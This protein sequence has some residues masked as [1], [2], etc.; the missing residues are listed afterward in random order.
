M[1]TSWE[2]VKA[3][4]EDYKLQHWIFYKTNP[5]KRED[6]ANDT[7]IDSNWYGADDMQD[8]L[9]MTEK[10][11]RHYGGTLYGVGFKAP[12]AKV[13][14]VYCEVRISA[15]YP[16]LQMTGIGAAQ[17]SLGGYNSIGELR[18]SITKEIRAEIAMENMKEREKALDKRERE[19][20]ERENSAMGAIAHYLAPVGQML[21][22]QRGLRNVAGVDAEQPVV[23]AARIAAPEEEQEKQLPAEQEAEQSP[24]TDE[25]ADKLFELMARFKKVEPQYMELL[26]GVVEMAERNDPMYKTAKGFLVK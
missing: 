20:R 22:Q 26:E 25:E 13:D 23:H 6:R 21:L 11:M 10:Y 1:F 3:W 14:G 2:Q 19:L 24:F 8:K 7:I 4:I 9:A 12:S 16:Q 5:E 17:Q 15:E 18:E